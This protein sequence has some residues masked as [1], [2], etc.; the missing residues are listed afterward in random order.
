M[1]STIPKAAVSQDFDFFLV[2]DFEATC[3][4]KKQ[5][6][7]QEIIEFPCLK[8]NGKTF[9]I[10]SVFHQYVKP[11][12][13]P[14]LTTFCTELTGIIQEMVND[15]P[16]FEQVM[17]VRKL[18]FRVPMFDNWMKK[19]KLL[20]SNVKSIFVTCGDWDLNIM[21]P[22]QCKYFAYDLPE[23][24]KTWINIKKVKIVIQIYLNFFLDFSNLQTFCDVSKIWPK[25]I[26]P[27]LEY[28]SLQ[29]RGRLH[30]GIGE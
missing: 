28:Y 3:E 11:R 24:M 4:N 5:I 26:R 19:E 14:Q 29:Q 17:E 27:M 13:H 22:N 2:L 8:V 1:A 20:D 25:G 15:E 6:Q 12:V 23:Y 18:V 9:E 16:H 7:P 10:D 30:S 21:L